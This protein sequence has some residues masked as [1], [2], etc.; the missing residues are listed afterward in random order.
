MQF[1]LPFGKTSLPLVI[2]D[3]HQVDFIVPDE[4][5]IITDADALIYK[6]LQNPIAHS[7]IT[8]IVQPGDTISIIVS[9]STRTTP[10]AIIL[11][12][13][14][15]ML[16]ST[17]VKNENIKIIFALG[18]HRRQSTN[19]KIS[20]V[21]K[22]IYQN[23]QCLDHD[24]DRCCYLG[25]TSRGTPVEIFKMVKESDIIICT[26]SIENHYFAGY[27]GGYKAVLPGVSSYRSIIANHSLMINEGT[28]PGNPECPV[29]ADLEEAGS[30]LGVDFI[31]N[32]ILNR[33]KQIIGAVAGHPIHAHRK[34]AQV[35]DAMYKQKVEPADIVIVSPGGW[36]K[37][38]DLFQSHKALEHV[39]S[40]VKPN[41]SVILGAQC[42]EGLGNAVFEQWLDTRPSPKEV[43]NR[44]KQDFILGGHKAALLG[45]L[46][47]EFSLFLV[48]GLPPETAQAAFFYPAKNMQEAFD[49][50]VVKH[51]P[52]AR[53]LIVPY[54][55][56]TLAISPKNPL[57]YRS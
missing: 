35:V 10:T 52:D 26:G 43:I 44:L 49:M 9:D 23:Y 55:G 36:P 48:S 31:L 5:H 38:I 50:A 1:E 28:F 40:A 4:K 21:G 16:S 34:G 24:K 42:C 51:G 14:L 12:P 3:T 29:R 47:L 13:L 53:I 7:P 8:D 18:I 22:D 25:T 33:K 19:E 30:I 2:P 27:T 41:G 39:K 37:D 45:K 54:G 11:P 20:I 6:A 32:V 15:E 57:S 46:A 17:G 56:S